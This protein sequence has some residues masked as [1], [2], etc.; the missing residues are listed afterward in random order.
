MTSF[1][2][3]SC[4]KCLAVAAGVAVV[5]GVGFIYSGYYPMGADEPHNDLTSWALETLRER[6]I[7]RASND[8]QVPTDLNSSERLLAGGADYN[9]MCAGCHL[10]P[11]VTQ[12]DFTLGLYPEPPNLSR[13]AT[14]QDDVNILARQR[15]WIIKHGIK[16]SGMPAWGPGHDDERIWSMVAFLQRLPELSPQQ[17]QILTARSVDD[18]GHH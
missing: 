15:F 4:F 6:S 7:A 12:S 10:K 3:L 18:A 13:T 17:Y 8:I 1:K 14:R 16:A 2:L 11:G 9:D 5:A